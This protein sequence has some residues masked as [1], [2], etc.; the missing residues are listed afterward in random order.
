[1]AAIA[2]STGRPEVR[3]WSCSESTKPAR[4]LT[5]EVL[6]PNRPSGLGGSFKNLDE[7]FL[8]VKALPKPTVEQTQRCEGFDSNSTLPPWLLFVFQNKMY[9]FMFSV[10]MESLFI[11]DRFSG[12]KHMLL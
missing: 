12:A 3:L 6:E 1:M 2:L 8:C 7:P 11:Q 9:P 4:P 5:L 10:R